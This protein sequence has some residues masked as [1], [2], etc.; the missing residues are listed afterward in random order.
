[1]SE[2]R[3]TLWIWRGLWV[4]V[5]VLFVVGSLIGSE[6]VRVSFDPA[7]RADYHFGSD[8]MREKGGWRYESATTYVASTASTAL[9]LLLAAASFARAAWSHSRFALFFGAASSIAIFVIEFLV[10]RVAG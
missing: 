1:M 6:S 7:V 10:R 9:L 4:A 2:G 5:A 3:A 8:S